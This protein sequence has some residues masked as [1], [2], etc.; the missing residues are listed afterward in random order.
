M[1]SPLPSCC[2]VTVGH[3]ASAPSGTASASGCSC[4]FLGIP[5]CL[6][7]DVTDDGREVAL[8]EGE[9]QGKSPAW[10]FCTVLGFPESNGATQYLCV[11]PGLAMPQNGQPQP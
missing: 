11:Q 3:Q 9:L 7:P 10:P 8:I 5:P 2:Q 1:Q 4:H 6:L